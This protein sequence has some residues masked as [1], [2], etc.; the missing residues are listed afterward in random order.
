MRV[1]DDAS[2]DA[3]DYVGDY[4]GVND[5][6]S[7]K[8]WWCPWQLCVMNVMTTIVVGVDIGAHEKSNLKIQKTKPKH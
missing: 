1:N 8:W 5:D 4:I 7:D 6:A 3:C 2:N